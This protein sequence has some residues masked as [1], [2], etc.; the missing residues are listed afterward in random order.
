MP[1]PQPPVPHI[2]PGLL[3]GNDEEPADPLV[4]AAAGTLNCFARSMP[5]QLGQCGTSCWVRTRVS[6]VDAQGS[7]RYS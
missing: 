7:Q 6:K 2:G 4:F 1:P 5:P 3:M